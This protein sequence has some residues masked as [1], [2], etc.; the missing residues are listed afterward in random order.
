M[1]AGNQTLLAV[2]LVEQLLSETS[3]GDVL[4][5]VSGVAS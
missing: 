1:P 4:L 3:Y 5:L 2:L